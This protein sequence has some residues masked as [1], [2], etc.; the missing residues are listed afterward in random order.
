MPYVIRYELVIIS[1]ITVFKL[2]K[3]GTYFLTRIS[4]WSWWR[5]RGTARPVARP[6]PR[7]E[8]SGSKTSRITGG[9][10]HPSPLD[11]SADRGGAVLDPTWIAAGDLG[12]G[13]TDSTDRCRAV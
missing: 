7:S 10:A 4:C 2:I 9:A 11:L 6:G 5:W 13:W 3:V 1:E 8:A 12:R